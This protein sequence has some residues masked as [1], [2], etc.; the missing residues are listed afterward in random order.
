MEEKSMSKEALSEFLNTM[1]KDPNLQEQL[2]NAAEGSGDQA[3]V[4]AERL[5]EIGEANGFEFTPE[6]VA[7]VGEL[8]DDELESV[9]G[10]AVFAK[11]D[12]VDGE[13]Q[14]ALKNMK[15]L[16]GGGVPLNNLF[17]PFGVKLP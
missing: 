11:Y 14:A 12:G 16:Y 3:T 10:G 1:A 13:A 7:G 15:N 6:D 9:A 4:S 8:S 5:V 2:R 17:G